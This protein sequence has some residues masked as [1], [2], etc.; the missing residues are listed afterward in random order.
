LIAALESAE[1]LRDPIFS[2]TAAA[3]L[4]FVM[5]DT[6]SRASRVFGGQCRWRRWWCS[7]IWFGARFVS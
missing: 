7:N 4:F 5:I 3:E 1:S 2:V 6:H